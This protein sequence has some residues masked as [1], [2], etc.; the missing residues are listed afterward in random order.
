MT[1]KLV[2][3]HP[4]K[5]RCARCHCFVGRHDRDIILPLC[6]RCWADDAR[7]QL[8]ETPEA[9]LSERERTVLAKHPPAPTP[10]ERFWRKVNKDGPEVRA[11][12]GA[13]WLW[14]GSTN[15]KYGHLAL[16]DRTF[17]GAHRFSWELHNGPIP[18]GLFVCHRCDNPL[19][20]NP[21]HLFLGT[22]TDNVRDME[23]KGRSRTREPWT[24][25]QRM[26]MRAVHA[27]QRRFTDD[28]VREMRSLRAA[29]WSFGRLARE[30]GA[31]PG[32]IERLVK[33]RTYADVR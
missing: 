19:C 16:T 25:A 32:V 28:Q 17:T 5:V 4:G 11:G 2:G 7:R 12:L 27:T 3:P 6:G 1:R 26:K 24:E 21:A 8:A 20:V 23:A 18:D 22:P 31:N 9:G 30:Y 29:G 15:G 10:A 13:C 33:G 14:T